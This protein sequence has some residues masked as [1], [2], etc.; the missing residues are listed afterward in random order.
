MADDGFHEIQ[1]DRKQLIFLFMS[2]AV[3]LVV[4]FLCGVLVGRGVRNQAGAEATQAAVTLPAADPGAEEAP[5]PVGGAAPA[6]AV[7]APQP[8]DEDLGYQARLQGKTPPPEAP[9]PAPAAKPAAANPPPPI[10]PA[11]ETAAPAPQASTSAG[12]LVQVAALSGRSNADAVAKQLVGKGYKAFVMAP[13]SQ[14]SRT[15]RVVIGRFKT[16]AEADE[17]KRRLEKEEGQFKPW[18]IS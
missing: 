14:G 4:A 2:A 7:A 18:I 10:E 8:V 15:Y 17:T 9:K 5:A 12:W 1:L 11:A 16:R 3:V 6:P 13:R